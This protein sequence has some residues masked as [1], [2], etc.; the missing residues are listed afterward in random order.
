MDQSKKQDKG[1]RVLYLKDGRG[2]QLD[3]QQLFRPGLPLGLLDSGLCNEQGREQEQDRGRS[4][5]R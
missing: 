5:R 2:K 3:F 4:S 1:G